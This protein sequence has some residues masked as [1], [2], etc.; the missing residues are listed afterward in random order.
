MNNNPLNQDHTKKGFN[1]YIVRIETLYSLVYDFLNDISLKKGFNPYNIRI[2]T[3]L[4]ISSSS[5][6]R[7]LAI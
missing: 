6:E 2:K 7:F 5:Y 4:Y 1:P 3:L